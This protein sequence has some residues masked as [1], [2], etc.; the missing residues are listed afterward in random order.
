MRVRRAKLLCAAV[1][2]FFS[3]LGGFLVSSAPAGAQTSQYFDLGWHNAKW[4]AIH[5]W[6]EDTCPWVFGNSKASCRYLHV[7]YHDWYYNYVAI[8][9]DQLAFPEW[10]WPNYIFAGSYGTTTAAVVLD[11]WSPYQAGNNWA[12]WVLPETNTAPLGAPCNQ[13]VCTTSPA[14]RV[15]GGMNEG[16]WISGYATHDTVFTQHYNSQFHPPTGNPRTV[17]VIAA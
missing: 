9:V 13:R 12:E 4:G 11:V 2:S 7:D 8:D 16:F 3:V 5:V 6:V 17:A 14:M 10:V 1:L 15:W